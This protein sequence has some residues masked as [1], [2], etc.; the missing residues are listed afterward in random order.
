[1]IGPSWVLTYAVFRAWDWFK[2]EPWSIAVQNGLAVV[3][4]GL[5]VSSAYLLVR[6]ADSD[7]VTFLLTAATAAA[8]YWTEINPLWMF[9]AA[10]LG[11]FRL[12]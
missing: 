9:A 7:S 1:M 10:G 6:A 3:T 12:V 11:I 4:A 8:A 2:H 5:V